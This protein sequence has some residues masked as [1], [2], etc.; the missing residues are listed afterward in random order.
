MGQDFNKSKWFPL[1]FAV[2]RK[3]VHTPT[4]IN[5]YD[6]TSTVVF[7]FVLLQM[8]Y[9]LQYLWGKMLP[10]TDDIKMRQA[11]WNKNQTMPS[12]REPVL[13]KS[14]GKGGSVICRI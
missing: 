6:L 2:A 7:N 14:L 1:V 9:I 8:K 5:M 10:S 3:E 4:S 13:Y 12:R 11:I